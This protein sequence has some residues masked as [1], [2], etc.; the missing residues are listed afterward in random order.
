MGRSSSLLNEI[1]DNRQGPMAK[2][3]LT[4]TEDSRFVSNYFVMFIDLLGQKQ[5]MEGHGLLPDD[6]E[7]QKELIRSV[8]LPIKTLQSD[9]TN[10]YNAFE[11]R[12]T[13]SWL[14]DNLRNE[15]QRLSKTELKFQRFSDGLVLYACLADESFVTQL[16]GLYAILASAGRLCLMGLARK[17]PIRGGCEL[18]WGV[19][20]NHN[21]I[22]GCAVAKAYELE[23][24]QAKL[25]RV[26][27]G[28]EV[29]DFI[30]IALQ[31]EGVDIES[32]FVKPLGGLCQNLLCH[33]PDNKVMIDFLGEFFRNNLAKTIDGKVF[34][35]AEDYVNEQLK[36]WKDKDEKLFGRY[37]NL[38][39]YFQAKRFLWVS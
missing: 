8:V 24:K 5:A 28:N 14:P 27:I 23:S 33:T 15:Y 1:H 11:T 19:E 13:P 37:Q 18:A 12:E 4:M 17:W 34:L 39:Q 2:E 26:L 35:M 30:K 6:P 10:F 21:E 16:N 36:Y 25:P 9:F 3:R 20:L 38:H 22:Y 31:Q 29:Q 32:G 7:Q